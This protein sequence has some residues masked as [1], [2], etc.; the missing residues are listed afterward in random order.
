MWTLLL[1]AAT[2]RS[3][4]HMPLE[5]SDR[6]KLVLWPGCGGCAVWS[7]HKK[8]VRSVQFVVKR[9]RC[10]CNLSG[11]V[12]LNVW[13]TTNGM[14]AKNNNIYMWCEQAII[15][16]SWHVNSIVACCHSANLCAHAAWDF[17]SQQYNYTSF[18]K[19]VTTDLE[20]VLEF[21]RSYIRTLCICR[22]TYIPLL[23]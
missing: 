20:A 11:D 3:F 23:H 22:S 10:C 17:R 7:L 21:H 16:W 5:I 6:N 15:E 19:V 13:F 4:A 18:W 9:S 1:L 12:A 2:V 14:C 8:N